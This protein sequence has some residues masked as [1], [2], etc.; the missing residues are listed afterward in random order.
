MNTVL[1]VGPGY[2][3]GRTSRAGQGA[4]LTV[5]GLLLVPALATTV[6]RLVPPTDDATALAASFIGYGVIPYAIALFC[7]LVALIRA[8]RRLVLAILTGIVAMLTALHLSWLG[9]LFVP[10]QRV[11]RTAPFTLM[12]INMY[13]GQA[14][15]VAVAD[16]AER[17]DIVILVEV[18]PAAL[19]ALQNQGWS[20]RFRYSV[21]Q[22][23]DGVGGTAAYSRFRMSQAKLIGPTAFG[24]WA[25]S[26]EVPD[27][28]PVQLMAVHPCNPYC[29]GGR[30]QSDHE[31]LRSAVTEHLDGPLIV[32]GDFNAVEDHAPMQRLRRLGLRSVSDV[33]G[34]G[35]QPTFPAGRRT[36]PP[37]LPIDHVLVNGRLTATSVTTFEVHGTDH[38]GI[39]TT[40]AGT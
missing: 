25:V 35:W 40:L 4:L 12:T 17:A 29:G 7:M 33:A 21:G 36:I 22:T 38:R 3:P 11:A 10:D 13:N 34:A 5:A 18:T 1:V 26:V 9:P 39:L 24:Q 2:R 28:G 30:W 31:L 16:L 8:R 32:A 6:M 19:R 27:I 20:E 37:L 23:E 15:P 14:D